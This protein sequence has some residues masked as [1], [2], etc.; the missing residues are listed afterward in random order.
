MG[1]HLLVYPGA[2]NLTTG[3][4]HWELLA[5]ARAVDN[6]LF[7]AVCSPARDETFSYIAWGHSSIIDPWGEGFKKLILVLSTCDEKENIIYSN[8]DSKI[9][10]E[11]ENNLPSYKNKRKDI[12]ELNWK[13]ENYSKF[14]LFSIIS[15]TTVTLGFIFNKYFKNKFFDLIK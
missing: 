10:T 13:K 6:Q 15:I 8:I 4:K 11:I 12:Y 5:R 3:P 7:V 1:C 9:I 2:F 14:K